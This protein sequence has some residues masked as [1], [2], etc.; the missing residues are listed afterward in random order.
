MMTIGIP[1]RALRTTLALFL[2]QKGLR[3]PRSTARLTAYSDLLRLTRQVRQVAELLPWPDMD[4]LFQVQITPS[5]A[6][7]N[8]NQV[9][10]REQ[11]GT[12]ALI[13]LLAGRRRP[14]PRFAAITTV[15]PKNR[16]KLGRRT[17]VIIVPSC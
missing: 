9:F 16:N 1:T 6:R 15:T 5:E 8:G 4:R 7:D 11:P 12:S 10:W 13:D 2:S 14:H 17:Y 3:T